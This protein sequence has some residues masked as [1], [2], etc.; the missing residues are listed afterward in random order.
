M[1]LKIQI[2]LEEGENFEHRIKRTPQLLGRSPGADIQVD[3]PYISSEHIT[4]EIT[5]NGVLVRDVGSSNGTYL[6][7][8][9]IDEDYLYVD[10]VLDLGGVQ[11]ILDKKSMS[12]R[13]RQIYTRKGGKKKSIV[14][15]ESTGTK[16]KLIRAMNATKA[17][18]KKG[19]KD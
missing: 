17:K 10:D 1:S 8:N 2:C 19:A 9:L 15:R 5:E 18:R 16:T 14:L 4:I 13:E 3:G 6:N 12:A 11:I 7:G